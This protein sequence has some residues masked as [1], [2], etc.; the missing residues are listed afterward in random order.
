[1]SI[2]FW[3]WI[4]SILASLYY[5]GLFVLLFVPVDGK[6]SQGRIYFKRRTDFYIAL[7]PFGIGS[8]IA[9]VIREVR[10]RA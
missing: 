1:M 4:A 9:A 8:F 3:I 6:A 2:T 10:S 7:V 5:L